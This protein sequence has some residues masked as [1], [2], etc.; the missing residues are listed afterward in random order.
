MKRT[1]RQIAPPAY[2]AALGLVNALGNSCSE[3]R[4]RMLSG[5]T[6]GM[7]REGG[8]LA[9]GGDALVGR[10]RT[11][12]PEL[13]ARLSRYECRNNRLLL[14]ALEQIGREVAATIAEFGHRRVGIV[15]GTS[16]SGIAEGELA[17]EALRDTGALPADFDYVCQEI[18]TPAVF[19]ARHLGL[20][21]PA[22]TVS[23]ACTSSAKALVSARMLLA[24][25][26]CDAV[27][28]GGVD[29]L[30]RLTVSGF[31]SLESVSPGH[32]NPMS[33]NRRGINI[34]EAAALFLLTRSPTSH[35]VLGCGESSDA[36]HVSAPHPEGRGAETAMRAALADAGVR[37]EAIGYINLHGTA[38]PKNDEMESLAMQRVFPH[39]PP[40]SSTKPLTG[41]TLGAAGATEAAFCYLTLTDEE[42]RLPPHVW[43]GVA[44]P[45]LPLLNLVRPGDRFGDGSRRVSMSNGF[46]FGG[47]NVSLILGEL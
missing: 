11:P 6:R 5:D 34:G 32:S 4:A 46:A 27:I 47:S 9:T 19:L 1:D 15:L 36:Y 26:T 7:T 3:V 23:T 20:L 2:I 40:A 33:A 22:Y 31:T 41:H 13:P 38:T 39:A 10:V 17:F 21:G 14:A 16:T 30:C 35:A 12:L 28:A 42:G 24:S 25:G 29:T 44:D 8:W 45:A 18:G 37:P 43:D